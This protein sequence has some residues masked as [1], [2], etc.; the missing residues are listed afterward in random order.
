MKSVS[1]LDT[2]SSHLPELMA[3]ADRVD[4]THDKIILTDSTLATPLGNKTKVAWLI[5]PECVIPASYAFIREC[6]SKFHTVITHSKELLQVLPNAHFIP[7]G[8]TFLT[9]EETGIH[10]KT[11]EVSIITSGKNFTHGHRFR[12]QVKDSLPPSVDVYGR[13]TNPIDSKL[14]GLKDY[15]YS[16]AIENSKHDYWFT[17]K[18]LDCFLTG[19]VPIYWGCP[20]IGDF[21]DTGGMMIIDS[22]EDVRKSLLK[23]SSEDYYSRATSIASNM[24][25]ALKYISTYD[26]VYSYVE[27]L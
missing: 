14:E 27:G 16:I 26:D 6:Y 13:G 25:S 22:E 12:L 4:L 7:F 23:C 18:L 9:T 19:T 21:F 11:K 17:E 15:R 20:S 10:H 2:T 1:F 24:K 8:T 3:Q 5:E